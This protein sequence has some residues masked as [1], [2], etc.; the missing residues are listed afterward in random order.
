MES[1]R[2][3]MRMKL[4]CD[5]VKLQKLINDPTFKDTTMYDENLCAVH[6]QDKII[7]FDKPLTCGFAILDISKTLMYDYYY[8]TLK[9]Y[10]S[11][12]I[13][14]MYMDTGNF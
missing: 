13:T 5:Y 9:K 3:R 14:L 11:N 10:Y 1:K 7:N 2:K 8:N 12:N 4:V 6:L